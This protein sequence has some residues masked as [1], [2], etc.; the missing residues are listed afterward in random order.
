SIRMPDIINGLSIFGDI[1][2]FLHGCE[3]VHRIMKPRAKDRAVERIQK[4]S[5]LVPA[6]QLYSFRRDA[7][8]DIRCL[9]D[10]LLTVRVSQ[11]PRILSRRA[12]SPVPRGV[13]ELGRPIP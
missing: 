11:P 12:D 3:A 2:I 4:W 6:V 13:L 5:T 1:L 10:L 7:V 8:S 9:N